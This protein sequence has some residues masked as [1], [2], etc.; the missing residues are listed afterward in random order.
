MKIFWGKLHI[1]TRNYALNYIL[2]PKLYE[3]T[4]CTLNYYTYHT[5]HPSITF[6]VTFDRSLLRVTNICFLFRWNKLK[7]QKHSCSKSIKTK[8]NFFYTHVLLPKFRF[9]SKPKVPPTH[10]TH[11]PVP[12]SLIFQ[13]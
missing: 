2:Y 3:C 1:T 11:R 7:S 12:L 4:L 8:T 6:A 9:F 13:I 5:L 10:L